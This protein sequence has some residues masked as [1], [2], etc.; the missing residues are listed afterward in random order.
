[1]TTITT[2]NN[3][4]FY[5]RLF[6]FF[7]R[8]VV[9]FFILAYQLGIC[10]VYVVFVASNVKDVVDEYWYKLDVRIYMVIFLL[11]LILINYVRNLKYLAPFSAV[12][13]IITFVGFGIT[14]YY[15]FSELHGLDE[16]E[17]IG[18]VQNWP[19]FFGTV[20]FSLE[21]IGVVGINVA[22][23]VKIFESE[24]SEKYFQN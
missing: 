14:L 12:S 19:L 1:M 17:A 22:W 24:I 15:I 3:K 16:R 4:Y 8:H 5:L 7:F 13:N 18:E 2:I 11:P 23:V 9:N 21:A 6:S 10:C 20:L